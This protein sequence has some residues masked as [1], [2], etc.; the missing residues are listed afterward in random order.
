MSENIA[1]N[2]ALS[3]DDCTDGQLVTAFIEQQMQSARAYEQLVKRYYAW[4]LQHCKRR[5]GNY[6]DA[7]DAT[8]DV[9]LRLYQKLH[10]YRGD[11]PFSHWLA[12]VV[13][14]HCHNLH[15]HLAK[16]SH[17]H[18]PAEQLSHELVASDTVD[19][20]ENAEHIAG[21]LTK[22]TSPIRHILQLRFF[23]DCSLK[24]IA[25]SLKISLSAAKARLYRGLQAFKQ[26]YERT[27]IITLS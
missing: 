7:E 24:Q 8:Q 3:L 21:M 10:L 27:G 19:A 22:L 26:E 15:K 23:A 16:H 14:N 12:R 4:I 18:Q 25:A 1:T 20:E 2:P 11:A 6:H 5:L 9:L 13:E 17:G